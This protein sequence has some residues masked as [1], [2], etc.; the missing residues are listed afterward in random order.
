LKKK[1]LRPSQRKG[2]NEKK[3]GKNSNSLVFS[4]PAIYTDISL[5]LI[6]G[7]CGE[8]EAISAFLDFT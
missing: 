3:W 2:K 7:T 4:P 8:L 1:W 5:Y 6:R